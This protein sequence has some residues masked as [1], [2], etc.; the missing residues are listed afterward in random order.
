ML[1]TSGF[2]RNVLLARYLGIYYKV[3]CESWKINIKYRERLDSS[4]GVIQ[5]L[6]T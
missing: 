4:S 2:I 5:N 3:L 1:V 6:L